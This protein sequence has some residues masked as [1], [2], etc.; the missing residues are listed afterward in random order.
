MI[1]NFDRTLV[2]V[3]TDRDAHYSR[4]IASIDDEGCCYVTDEWGDLIPA[5][6][7]D[8]LLFIDSAVINGTE[9]AA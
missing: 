3:Y 2:A 8:D 6:E 9:P 1:A 7:F 4:P 5:D